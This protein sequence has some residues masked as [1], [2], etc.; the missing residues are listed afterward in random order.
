M[1]KIGI[2][3]TAIFAV[4]LLAGCASGTKTSGKT[5]ASMHKDVKGETDYKGEKRMK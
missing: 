3:L 4:A 1:K 2:V 5:S